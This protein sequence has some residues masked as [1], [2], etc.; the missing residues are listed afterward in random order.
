MPGCAEKISVIVPVYNTEKYLPICLRTCMEQTLQDIEIICVNDGSTD[1]SL[2]ILQAFQRE[3]DRIVIIDKPNGGLSSARNAGIR[4]A[5]GE[6]LVF[7]DSDDKLAK[8]ACERVWRE[9]KEAPTDI[10][11][12]GTDYFPWYPDPDL[13]LKN[14]L[15]VPTGRYWKFE[16]PV[17]FERSGSIPFVWRQAYRRSLLVENDLYFDEEIKFG[18]DTVFQIEMFPHAENFAFISDMLYQYR[19]CRQGS[20]M[21]EAAKDFDDKLEKHMLMLEH[22]C[23]YWQEQGWIESYGTELLRWILKFTVPDTMKPEVEQRELHHTHLK[24]VLGQY[25]L[26]KYKADLDRYDME[27]FRKIR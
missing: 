23:A 7:L 5:H 13:W 21:A 19:W 14:V 20:L 12:F 16:P 24:G 18:E 22:I 15:R 11:A 1:G 4:A 26:L 9:T 10:V 8:N 25:G 2:E 6:F 27:L 17:L 3:D